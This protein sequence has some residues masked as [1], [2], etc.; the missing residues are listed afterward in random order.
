MD[1]LHCS[2]EVRGKKYSVQ[3]WV[4]WVA[5]CLPTCQTWS[6]GPL[7]QTVHRSPWPGTASKSRHS[8]LN[9]PRAF[10]AAHGS[11][12]VIFNWTTYKAYLSSIFDDR[13][14]QRMLRV[15]LCQTHKDSEEGTSTDCL[16]DKQ[17]C[18]GNPGLSMSNSASFVKHDSFHL[19]RVYISIYIHIS[20]YYIY[21]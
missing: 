14:S 20:M 9:S 11:N 2:A 8:P 18:F 5:W 15:A 4:S 16:F 10:I 19:I 12:N 13:F 1:W 17:D 6:I 21:S 3:R 7:P